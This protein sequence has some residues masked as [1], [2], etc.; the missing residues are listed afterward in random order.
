[1]LRLLERQAGLFAR[2]FY[3]KFC[4]VER[5]IPEHMTTSVSEVTIGAWFNTPL[6]LKLQG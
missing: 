3:K 6:L 5:V 1:M 4:R 2:I